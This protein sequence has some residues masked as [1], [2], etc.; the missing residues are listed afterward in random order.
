MSPSPNTITEGD[1]SETISFPS[2]VN[3]ER[4]EGREIQGRPSLSKCV[5]AF[6]KAVSSGKMRRPL[7]RIER[8]DFVSPRTI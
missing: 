6:R 5:S 2:P 3:A 7:C 8:A 1:V 4:G